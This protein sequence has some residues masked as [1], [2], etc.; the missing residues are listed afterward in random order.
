MKHKAGN[1]QMVATTMILHPLSLDFWCLSMPAGPIT[2]GRVCQ[3][4]CLAFCLQG[5]Q[6]VPELSPSAPFLAGSPFPLGVLA[7]KRGIRA[8]ALH[9]PTPG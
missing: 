8:Q 2:P 7:L 9:L 5:V 3:D 1:E 6:E 4:L